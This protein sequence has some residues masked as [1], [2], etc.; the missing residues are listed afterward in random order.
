MEE[1][2]GLNASKL[3]IGKISYQWDTV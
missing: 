3:L 1:S 2:S